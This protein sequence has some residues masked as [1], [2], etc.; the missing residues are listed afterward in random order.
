MKGVI[1]MLD[2]EEAKGMV[3]WRGCSVV[4][5]LLCAVALAGVIIKLAL[6]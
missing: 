3:P 5:F 4:L 6:K 2:E 1:D